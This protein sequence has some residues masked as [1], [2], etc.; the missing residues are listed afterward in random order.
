MTPERM[1]RDIAAHYLS[2]NFQ[3]EDRLAVVLVHKRSGAVLQRLA[4][5]EQIAA[6]GFQ[7]WLRHKNANQCE[8]YVSMNALRP[9]A[10]GRT[11]A[12]VAAIRHVYLDFDDHGTEAVERLLKRPDL[13]QPNHL[14]S[15][16]PD[17]W[18]VVWRVQGFTKD[19]AEGLQRGLARDTGADPAATDCSRV[20][21]LPGFYNHKY[22]QKHLIGVQSLSTEIVGPERF[23]K[24]PQDERPPR[25]VT[26][27]HTRRAPA[28]ISQSER[29][30]AYAKR[31]LA[32]GDPEDLIVA[33]IAVHRRFD[34]YNPKAY[35]EHTVRKA[36]Q[37]L[38]AEEAAHEQP[39]R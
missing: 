17:K 12:D 35:A 5:S 25:M 37:A 4:T 13:P 20:L 33:A 27:Q 30:W 8:V 3:P 22:S 24:F 39:E 36:A 15:S 10:R 29:D 6:A 18:Q 28:G 7:A 16:S 21:R 34:K 19:Q 9:D 1:N 2:S 14:V 38:R 11:K 32:R 23:P 26:G 31:A